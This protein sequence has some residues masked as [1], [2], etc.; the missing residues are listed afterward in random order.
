M[1]SL[2]IFITK[3]EEPK[4]LWNLELL[5]TLPQEPLSSTV[6]VIRFMEGATYRQSFISYL[7]FWVELQQKRIYSTRI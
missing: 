3:C 1:H 5:T 2:Y 7:T 6:D 4:L